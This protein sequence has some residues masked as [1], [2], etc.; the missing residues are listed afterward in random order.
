M[1]LPYSA[2]DLLS[3]ENPSFAST[4]RSFTHRCARPAMLAGL[5]ILA[6][7]PGVSHVSAQ[8]I[9]PASG[10]VCDTAVPGNN[11]GGSSSSSTESSGSYSRPV[12]MNTAIRDQVFSSVAGNFLQMLFSSD[13]QADAQK[14][15]MMV[16]MQKREEEAL[17]LNKIAE[18]KQLAEICN[19]LEASLKLYGGPDLKLKSSASAS[20]DLQLK[21]GDSNSNG[22]V[23]IRGLP[24]I[25]LNDTTGNGGSTPYGISGL[26]GIYTNGPTSESAT[27]GPPDPALSLKMGDDSPTPS[28]SA[29]GHGSSASQAA[30]ADSAGSA[31][32]PRNMTP[33]QL[34]D[35]A[36][37]IASLPPAEQQRLMDAAASAAKA[38]LA[39]A[40]AAAP[41]QPTA[42][43]AS[44]QPV[45]AQL[46][47]IA[48]ASQ[49]AVTAA[50]PEGA[51]ALARTGFDTPAAGALA[52]GAGTPVALPNATGAPQVQLSATAPPRSAATI[53]RL[54]IHSIPPPLPAGISPAPSG[55]RTL[56]A[57]GPDTG[58]STVAGGDCPYGVDKAVP[59]RQQL[60]TELAVRRA[61][62]ESLQNTITRFNRTIQLDQ[63]QY[64]VWEDEAEA[65]ETR[66]KEHLVGIF[67]N[68]VFDSF[69]DRNEAIFEGTE[70]LEKQGIGKMSDF[71][72]QQWSWLK[73]AKE[74]KG[75]DD[76]QQWVLSHK[77]K[78]EMIDEGIRQLSVLNPEIQS[79]LRCYE[80][81]IDNAYDLTD[82]MATMDNVDRL[83]R[84]TEQYPEIV[85]QNGERM[86][87]L[88]TR[89]REID[90]QLNATPVLPPGTPACVAATPSGH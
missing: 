29:P 47:Q 66:V 49:A 28:A 55:A 22:H 62:L 37:K 23:G 15:Q 65:G 25:A 24:G 85:R 45:A 78:A 54:A 86:K 9:P 90:Q 7:F 13:D 14:Q 70:S 69:V 74:L 61:Q 84:N 79:Y 88:V 58:N 64:A 83:N 50:T 75:F 20:S 31:T 19:R 32:D 51:A 57:T 5:M 3:C 16:E 71:D 21:L 59:T 63:Q 38:P 12:N 43:A 72:K 33:Q 89:I 26:P 36:T 68:A 73:R 56:P 82:M 39:G 10:P 44:S 48:G 34:A 53:A 8:Y 40:G 80:D 87:A 11:C 6:G 46:Q 27:S 18:A 60:Q 67:K 30:S 4:Q 81:L 76:L 77:G 41:P 1:R 17:R 2:F 52:P 35:M 42:S